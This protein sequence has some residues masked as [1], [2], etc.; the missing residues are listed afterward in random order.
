MRERPR[1]LRKRRRNKLQ[2]ARRS[3]TR[4]A[5]K[6]SRHFTFDSARPAVAPI[7]SLITYHGSQSRFPHLRLNILSPEEL[8]RSYSVDSNG[9]CEKRRLGSSYFSWSI[10]SQQK[11]HPRKQD[12]GVA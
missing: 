3:F 12:H 11:K 4:R 8:P 10:A 5:S 6:M 2:R 7:T 1:R 9:D